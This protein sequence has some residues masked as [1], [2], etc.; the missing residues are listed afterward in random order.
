M[1][2]L[3][4]LD[5]HDCRV[6]LNM[7]EATSELEDVSVLTNKVLRNITHFFQPLN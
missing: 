3:Y 2:K 6:N 1:Q 4:Y 7:A 5:L